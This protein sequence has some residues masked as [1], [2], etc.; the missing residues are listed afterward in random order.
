MLCTKKKL[1]FKYVA[2]I[3]FIEKNMNNWQ[4]VPLTNRT[5]KTPNR[6]LNRNA[7]FDVFEQLKRNRGIVT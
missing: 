4:R 2:L 3:S 5:L 7:K 1:L 6:Q